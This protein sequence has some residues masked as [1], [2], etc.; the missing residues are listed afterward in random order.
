MKEL[1]RLGDRV[2][3]EVTGFVGI[4][5]GVTDWLATCRRWVIQPETLDKDGKVIEAHAFD[6]PHVIVVKRGVVTTANTTPAPRAETPRSGGP[7]P[8]PTRAATPR[9]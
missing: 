3:D 5:I 6:E 9:R 4:A 1:P 8:T 7:A 2:K